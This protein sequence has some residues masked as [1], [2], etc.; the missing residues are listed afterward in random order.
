MLWNLHIRDT[1][2]FLRSLS[3]RKQGAGIQRW[4]AR[5]KSEFRVFAWNEIYTKILILLK[6]DV[7]LRLCR[8]MTTAVR[9]T[10]L[11]F[12]TMKEAW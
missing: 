10:H 1:M 5:L 6:I 12:F 7:K 8:I 3:L 11:V 2:S 9:G 4:A